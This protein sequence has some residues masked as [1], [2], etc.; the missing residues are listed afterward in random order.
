M[1]PN[2]ENITNTLT[3][4]IIIIK[5]FYLVLAFSYLFWLFNDPS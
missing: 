1:N 3:R 4:M 5:Y 2:M